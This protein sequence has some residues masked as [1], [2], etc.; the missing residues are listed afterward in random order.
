MYI[1]FSIKKT[2]YKNVTLKCK[3]KM[4]FFLLTL[5]NYKKN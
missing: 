3:T 1:I 2:E 5:I 4:G